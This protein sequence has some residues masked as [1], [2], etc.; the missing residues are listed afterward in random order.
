MGAVDFVV[1]GEPASAKNQRRIVTIGGKP[2]V[3][4]SAK[5][6]RYAKSFYEQCPIRELLEG[7]LAL[8]LDV[9]YASRR[10]D[11][12]AI[13]LVQDLLQGH[14]YKNDRQIKM[15]FSVWNLDREKPR[16]RIRVQLLTI[17]GCTELSS[18]ALSRTWPD[19]EL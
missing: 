15:S 18:Y 9:W 13:D 7:D 19:L 1:Y 5:A 8:R 17:D 11:L 6:L 12:A 14:V 16:V 3:I 10:P 2:R 4:K